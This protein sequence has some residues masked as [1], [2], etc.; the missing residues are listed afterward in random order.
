MILS[1][2]KAKGNNVKKRLLKLLGKYGNKGL[3][4]KKQGAVWRICSPTKDFDFPQD[5]VQELKTRGDIH[6]GVERIKITEKG[7]RLLKAIL[8]PELG[9]S[10]P[11][12]QLT[13]V[14]IN[15]DG[16]K[17]RAL[18]NV[19]ES[20]LDRLY[21]RK[22]VKGVAYIDS[23]EYQAGE[24][25]RKDFERGQL[26]PRISANLSGSVG[27]AGKKGSSSGNEISDFALD[28][29]K[30]V[31]NAMMILGPELSGVAVDICC[32]LKGLEL[33]ERERKWPP[34]S[35]KLMLKTGLSILA[36]HYGFSGNSNSQSKTMVHWGS[37][38]FRP[39]I[40]T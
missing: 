33:V 8:E 23:H 25:L 13:N 32:F 35:A 30:R 6:L 15:H 9:H 20:P 16:R 29:R 17:Q 37:D 11:G 4:C 26:Q 39:Q 18:K 3:P 14:E 40:M 28:A 31:E 27:S 36:R 2:Q 5:L 34:R 7:E 19:N 21:H 38:D 22:S 10:V 12:R 24:R 1:G